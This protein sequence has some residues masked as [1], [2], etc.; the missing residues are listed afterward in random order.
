MQYRTHNNIHGIVGISSIPCLLFA[1]AGCP[2]GSQGTAPSSLNDTGV[3]WRKTIRGIPV[4]CFSPEHVTVLNG[5]IVVPQNAM[6]ESAWLPSTD[7][8]NRLL[9]LLPE[10]LEHDRDSRGM[11]AAARLRVQESMGIAASQPYAAQIIGWIVNGRRL[12]YGNFY[13][14]DP[15]CSDPGDGLV[16]TLDGGV[17]Y[18]QIWFDPTMS[19]FPL[20]MINGE[21]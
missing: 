19:A 1:L 3:A 9:R 18:F 16:L 2:F 6:P 21:A 7:V 10:R 5:S 14:C 17:D 15:D 11:Q 4:T 8:V 20:I 12:V 13:R